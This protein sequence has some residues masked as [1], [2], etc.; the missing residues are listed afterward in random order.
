MT[1]V[2]HS[3]LHAS[4]L[5]LAIA[6]TLSAM[7]A[8]ASD[9]VPFRHAAG[10]AISRAF[11]ASD[12]RQGMG[13]ASIPGTAWLAHGGRW[14]SRR[15]PEGQVHAKAKASAANAAAVDGKLP[16]VM[17]D[18]TRSTEL[19]AA[20]ESWRADEEFQGN[21]GLQAIGAEYA[22]A[23]GLTGD[24]IRIGVFDSGVDDRSEELQ[25][26][27]R[28]GLIDTG[29]ILDG[30][31]AVP[32]EFGAFDGRPLIGYPGE[33]WHGTHVAGTIGASRNGE[34]V[35]GVAFNS[36]LLSATHFLPGEDLFV[37]ARD[38]EGRV[39]STIQN[40]AVMQ[41][42]AGLVDRGARIINNSWGSPLALYL[43]FMYDLDRDFFLNFMNHVAADD[44][45]IEAMRAAKERDVV[46]VFAAGNFS[47]EFL[48]FF[49][50][51][52]HA[53]LQSS[54]PLI[55]PDLESHTLS[56]VN[57]TSEDLPNSSSSLCGQTLYWCVSAPGTDILSSAG[58]RLFSKEHLESLLASSNA[59]LEEMGGD[60]GAS[61]AVGDS[62]PGRRGRA[63]HGTVART[64]RRWLE[65]GSHWRFR[66][67]R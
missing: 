29:A 67:A 24:G 4:S 1:Q 66:T 33:S 38:G 25:G 63:N 30:I 3:P 35:Q 6:A 20:A 46:S 21:W 5:A 57:L 42:Y 32:G 26:E 34:G 12:A 18:G 7:P 59:A 15:V 45:L 39:N 19:E 52:A 44:P 13:D 31:E 10:D 36:G 49:R 37:K 51:D 40:Q 41:S 27:G 65:L 9:P 53:S 62:D 60:L 56:V 61:I 50:I 54:L 55:A 8:M 11:A 2:H 22:Y 23:R 58:G 64:V 16:Y 17:A 28:L 48:L 14:P 47:R 43:P